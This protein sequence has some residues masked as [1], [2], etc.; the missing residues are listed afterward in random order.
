MIE[1]ELKFAVPSGSEAFLQARLEALP[2]V[3]RFEE[4]EENGENVSTDMYYDT[5]AYDAFR[6]AIFMRIRN[7]RMLEFKFHEQDDPDHLHS[8]E[9]VFPLDADAQQM[10]EL[11][12]LCVRLLPAWNRAETLDA[13]FQ[14][15]DLRLFVPIEKHRTR[16]SYQDMTLCLDSVTGLGT[17][18]EIETLC[19][20]H[21]EIEQ[22][23][24]RLL[25]VVSQLACPDLHPVR[26]GYVELWLRQ[27]MP[28][29]Y[30][31]GKYQA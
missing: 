19:E 29:V 4:S 10:R 22:A 30:T 21:A 12:A 6:R 13:L 24:T 3:R 11:N 28:Q 18:L 27:H 20:T 1:V 31:L 26:I 16:Y 2:Q 7:H 23:N 5:P 8:T 15:N 17:F 25:S 14:A 9:L